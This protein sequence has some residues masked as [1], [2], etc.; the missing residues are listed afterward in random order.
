MTQIKTT[1]KTPAQTTAPHLDDVTS[2]EN[3][4]HCCYYWCAIRQLEW[5]QDVA[6]HKT[7][8]N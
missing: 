7:Y 4:V 2:R 1:T 8:V 3:Y 6:R 5:K